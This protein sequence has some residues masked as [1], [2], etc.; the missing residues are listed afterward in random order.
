[1]FKDSY[2]EIISSTCKLLGASR[3]VYCRAI[4]SM[5]KRQSLATTVVELVRNTPASHSHALVRGNCTILYNDSQAL[6]VDTLFVI[7]TVNK[8][9]IKPK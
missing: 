1:M 3:Q 4:E 8:I 9:L 6:N 7:L 5:G 2:D